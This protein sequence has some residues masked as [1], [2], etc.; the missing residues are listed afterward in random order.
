[1]HLIGD[2]GINYVIMLDYNKMNKESL[3]IIIIKAILKATVMN[4][5][6]LYKIQKIS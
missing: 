6:V 2:H 1:M 4:V 3:V 5:N